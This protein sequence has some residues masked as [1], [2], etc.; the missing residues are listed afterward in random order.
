MKQATVYRLQPRIEYMPPRKQRFRLRY[1]A[2]GLALAIVLSMVGRTVPY[3][4]EVHSKAAAY[5]KMQEQID[6]VA[7]GMKWN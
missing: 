1:I 6:I 4:M 2:Y 5:D 3:V 7:R